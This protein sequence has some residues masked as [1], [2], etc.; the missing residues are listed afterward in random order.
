MITSIKSAIAY[1]GTLPNY[2]IIHVRP[3][4]VELEHYSKYGYCSGG[5]YYMWECVYIYDAYDNKIEELE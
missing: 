3:G 1:L 5:S 4:C 2:R